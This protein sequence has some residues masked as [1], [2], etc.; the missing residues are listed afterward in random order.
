[1]PLFAVEATKNNAQLANTYVLYMGL[2]EKKSVKNVPNNYEMQA[3]QFDISMQSLNAYNM[4]TMTI[5]SNAARYACL[6]VSIEMPQTVL[7]T[8]H[9]HLTLLFEMMCLFFP[10]Y[11]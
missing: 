3:V 5:H 11:A 10:T 8:F 2:Q 9:G 6:E 7:L 4:S 1:M